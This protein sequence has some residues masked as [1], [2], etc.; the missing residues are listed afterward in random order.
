MAFGRSNSLS[1]NTGAT[2]NLFSQQQQNTSQ[3]AQTGGLFGASS[4]A[5]KPGGLFGSSNTGTTGPTGGGLFGSSTQQ[6]S[7]PQQ[8][9]GLFGGALGQNQT[10]NQNQSQQPGQTGS[11]LFGGLGQN[12]AQSQPA[13]GGGLF[14][15]L[16]QSQQAKPSGLFPSLGQSTQ[17]PQQQQTSLFGGMNQSQQQQNKPTGLFPSLGQSTQQQ[18]QQ[19]QQ[20]S[21]PS[22]LSASLFNA[23]LPAP[24]A[25]SLT[26]GQPTS[27]PSTTQP[28]VKIDVSQVRPTTRF[29]DLHDDLKKQIEALDSFIKTQESYAAQCEALLPSHGQNVESLEPDVKLIESKI[30]TVELGLENDGRDIGAA[31]ESL[32]GDVKDLFRCVRVIENLSLPQRFHYGP[33]LGSVRGSSSAAG[34]LDEEYDVDLMGFF[35]REVDGMEKVAEGFWAAIGEVEQHL[36]V[37]E[38]SA[39]LAG[40]EKEGR[41]EDTVRELAETLRGFEGGILDAAG[42]VGGVREGVGEL[43]LGRAGY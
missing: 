26:M 32:K 3:P 21:Q 22:L 27:V 43:V 10:Q 16:G 28:G 2:N 7:Q 29:S 1:I 24:L 13:Q 42:K 25:G 20:Q 4:N 17:Q 19:Q 41:G 36:G 30:E 5:P 11:S 18:P 37:V 35:G 14:G 31:K 34:G 23:P 9:G 12:N 40:R 6:Q 33:S 15:G 8:S 38:R 39:V